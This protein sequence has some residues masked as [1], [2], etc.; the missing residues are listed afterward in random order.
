MQR[1][2]YGLHNATSFIYVFVLHSV[3]TFQLSGDRQARQRFGQDSTIIHH[4]LWLI[5]ERTPHIQEMYTRKRQFIHNLSRLA[6]KYLITR[7][8]LT[9]KAYRLFYVPPGLTFKNSA[10]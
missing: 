7:H 10:W 5:H 2:A 8:V 1:S 3:D 9:F 4:T 6:C